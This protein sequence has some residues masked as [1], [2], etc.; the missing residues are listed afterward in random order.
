[1]KNVYNIIN[2][3]RTFIVP[4]PELIYHNNYE[5]LISV[6]L[7]AQ[8][9]DKH[10]N[11]V[12][13]DLFLKYSTPKLLSEANL[14]QVIDIIKPLGL[15]RNKSKN[16]IELSKIIVE[17]YDGEVP[18]TFTALT[19]LP[20]V[21]RKTAQVVLALGFN[22]P[23]LPVDTHVFRVAKRL[24]LVPENSN[25]LDVELKLKEL[26]KEEDWIEVHHLFLL[27]GR[28][29]CMAKNPMCDGCLLK[30]YCINKGR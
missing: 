30:K 13:K 3:L 20:G 15:Y 22:I 18:Q 19:S 7:S 5:L 1:M 4:K 24:L 8:T 16:I 10:V 6:V 21:G 17:K 25:I 11:M 27:F 26:V 12:T 14:L 28:Y 23:S 9:T 2:T 29:Y